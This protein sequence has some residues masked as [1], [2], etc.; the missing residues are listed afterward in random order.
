MKKNKLIYVLKGI[1]LRYGINFFSGWKLK[2][3][4]KGNYGEDE[5]IRESNDK[6]K[7]VIIF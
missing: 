2:Y 6:W 1:I 4:K 5:W 3:K 7:D